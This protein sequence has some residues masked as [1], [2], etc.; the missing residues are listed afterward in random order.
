MKYEVLFAKE[1]ERDINILKKSEPTAFKKLIKLIAELY[2]HP[3]TGTGKPEK[4]KGDRTGQWSR[5]ITKKH[6]LI[7]E[8]D[9][10][11]VYVYVLSAYGHY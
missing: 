7:Y 6:R 2:E 11:K 10:D 3:M 4:L 9:G 8:I 1:A 5:R